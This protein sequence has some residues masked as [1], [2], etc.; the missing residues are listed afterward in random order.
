MKKEMNKKGKIIIPIIIL[1]I[2]IVALVFVILYYRTDLFHKANYINPISLENQE[3]MNDNS[4]INEEYPETQEDNYYNESLE[5]QE[6]LEINEEG[7]N[8]LVFIDQEDYNQIKEGVDQFK[9]DVENNFPLKLKIINIENLKNYNPSEIRNILINNCELSSSGCSSLE[10]AVFVGD[11][12]YAL[13]TQKYDNWNIGPFMFYYQDLDA[14]FKQ[15]SEGYYYEYDSLGNQEGPEIYVSWIKPINDA[16]FGTYH[17]Q[18]ENYFEKHHRYLTGIVTPSP[19]VV[20]AWH[21]TGD[22]PWKINM[23]SGTYNLENIIAIHP[24]DVPDNLEPLLPELKN[25]LS[26]KPEVAFLHS[27]GSAGSLFSMNKEALLEL[28]GQPLLLFS[29]GCSNGNF[30]FDEEDILRPIFN[31]SDSFPLAYINGKELGLSFFGKI[32]SMDMYIENGVENTAMGFNN[33]DQLFFQKW[34]NGDY[35]GKIVLD[36]EQKFAVEDLEGEPSNLYRI[37]G[38]LQRIIIG[39]PFVR[40]AV[41]QA[42]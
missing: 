13:Y 17:E 39:S 29:W 11:I 38:P 1:I 6:N 35:V 16:S 24:T 37:S 15:N 9:Q 14:T 18:L 41:A 2:L 23:F 33:L 30:Y 12:P 3:N 26:E 32:D 22:N 5:N 28:E 42:N 40:S 36:M 25:H 7:G 10:G 8:V 20:T 31:E 34:N 4:K 21:S 27:H 19:K